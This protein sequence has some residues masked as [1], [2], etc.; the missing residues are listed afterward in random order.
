MVET[1]QFEWSDI[2]VRALGREFVGIRGIT[3]S[4]SV[5]NEH[6][7]GRGRKPI[8]IQSGNETCEGEI[9]LLQSELQALTSALGVVN[10]TNIRFDIVVTYK[11]G[12]NVVTDLIKSVKC[13]EYEKSM[14]QGDAFMEISIPFLA[15]DIIENL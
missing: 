2:R 9:T 6:L 12:D 13:N 10:L 5:E 8:A 15:L 7:H 14:S 11:N 4:R 1:K 3:Y